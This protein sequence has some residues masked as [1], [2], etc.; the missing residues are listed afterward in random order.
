LESRRNGLQSS[1]IYKQFNKDK[2]PLQTTGEVQN[3]S[4]Y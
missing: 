3:I 1:V 4:P 2:Y